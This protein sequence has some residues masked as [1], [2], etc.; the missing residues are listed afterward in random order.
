M[1]QPAPLDINIL[2]E[3]YRQG[4]VK[5][6]VAV[7]T[8]VVAM[9]LFGLMPAYVVLT[10]EQARTA[11]MQA[12]LDQIKA[13]LA[14]SQVDQEQLAQLDEQIEE[15]RAQVVQLH[16]ELE[17]IGKE[18][19]ARSAGIT[20]IASAL[21]PQ[22]RI[23]II[24]QDENLF[25]FKGTTDDPMLVLNYASALQ[26]SGQFVNVRILSITNSDPSAVEFSI[27]LEQ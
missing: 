7:V 24:S 15:T 27:E 18:R 1:A 2:P 17:T 25:T 6:L 12:H 3:R 21:V 22:I 11:E 9:L 20:T 26:S 23:V 16:Q 13:N 8:L 19:P 14:Q 4:Q 5:P 10:K